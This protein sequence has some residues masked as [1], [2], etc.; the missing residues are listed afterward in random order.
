MFPR[1]RQSFVALGNSIEAKDILG[2]ML[3]MQLLA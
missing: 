3:K 2:N 1:P